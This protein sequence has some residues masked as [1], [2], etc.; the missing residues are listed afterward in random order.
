[1]F[2][3]RSCNL[4]KS[5]GAWSAPAIWRRAAVGP[6]RI[7]PHTPVVVRRPSAD[8]LWVCYRD[9]G[10]SCDYVDAGGIH[11][12]P[13][14]GP[15]DIVGDISAAFVDDTLFVAYLNARSELIL[16]SHHV[17]D[18]GFS[19]P[20]ALRGSG[21]V[22]HSSVAPVLASGVIGLTN[23]LFIAFV[24]PDGDGLPHATVE[25]VN[26]ATHMLDAGWTPT[27]DGVTFFTGERPALAIFQGR[28]HLAI[29]AVRDDPD[30]RDVRAPNSVWITTV[31]PPPARSDAQSPLV[32]QHGFFFTRGFT[33]YEGVG[34]ALHFVHI[35]P[36]DMRLA[37]RFKMSN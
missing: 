19:R 3:R 7:V 31:N 25:R 37:R 34:G 22:M 30:S 27:S 6:D 24:A 18:R 11:R 4:L 36:D 13:I 5:C 15:I 2:Q 9:S 16:F 23:P 33:F 8:E 20:T 21:G 32:P 35:A 1:M 14:S 10:I 29:T 17:G 12:G 28:L 26:T